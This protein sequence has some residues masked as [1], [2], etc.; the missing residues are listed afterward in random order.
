LCVMW[1]RVRDGETTRDRGGTVATPTRGHKMIVQRGP[2]GAC[3]FPTNAA[4]PEMPEALLLGQ[5][6]PA[7]FFRRYFV[8]RGGFDRLQ[9]RYRRPVS[10]RR[11][12]HRSRPQ[13]RKARGS[14]G[15]GAD[16]VINLKTAKALG[17]D[18]PSLSARPRRR[19]DRVAQLMSAYGTKGTCEACPRMSAFGGG[20]DLAQVTA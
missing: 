5:G 20:A 7:V 3:F 4:S 16:Q 10:P 8:D 15:A 6:P 11:R 18:L 13:G 9:L 17:L 19:G 2:G 12:L 14:A 1:S